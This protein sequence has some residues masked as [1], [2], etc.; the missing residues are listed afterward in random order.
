M[1]ALG[2]TAMGY[3]WIFQKHSKASFLTLSIFLCL[4]PLF[5]FYNL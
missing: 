5:N 2:K 4:H 3:M 1:P